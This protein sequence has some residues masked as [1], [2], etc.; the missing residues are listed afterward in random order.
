MT[1]PHFAAGNELWRLDAPAGWHTLYTADGE[2]LLYE[3]WDPNT[4][5]AIA[6]WYRERYDLEPRWGT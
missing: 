1:G 3:G 4:A 2:R 6:C 5:H